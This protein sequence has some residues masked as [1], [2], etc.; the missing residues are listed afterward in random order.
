[1]FQ[2]STA[3]GTHLAF[4]VSELPSHFDWPTSTVDAAS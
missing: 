4:P 1:L 3:F 2:R